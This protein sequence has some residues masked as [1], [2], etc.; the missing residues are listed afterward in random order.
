MTKNL[1]K[2]AALPGSG[3]GCV[4]QM[5]AEVNEAKK[6]SFTLGPYLVV[7]GPQTIE[8]EA[9]QNPGDW[10]PTVQMKAP[11]FQEID[12]TGFDFS[13]LTGGFGC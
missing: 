6:E 10:S 7:F 5:P 13:G 8:F 11:Y 12:W 9:I 4:A 2:V 3:A 1:L